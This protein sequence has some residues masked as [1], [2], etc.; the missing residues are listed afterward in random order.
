MGSTTKFLDIAN[1]DLKIV[2]NSLVK[3]VINVSFNTSTAVTEVSIGYEEDLERV[4]KTH[5][6]WIYSLL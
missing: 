2:N 1:S 4:E 6:G 3:N 5:R